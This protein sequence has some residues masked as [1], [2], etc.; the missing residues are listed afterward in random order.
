MATRVK[1][2]IRIIKNQSIE[3]IKYII[4][5]IELMSWIRYGIIIITMIVLR[6]DKEFEM[7]FNRPS[8]FELYSLKEFINKWGC[9]S[10]I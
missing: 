6:F 8:F 9:R 10:T 3:C 1:L 4:T 5:A 2:C 7:V